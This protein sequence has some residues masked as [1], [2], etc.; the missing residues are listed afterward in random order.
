MDNPNS[1]HRGRLLER[2]EK[3]G[4]SALSD[5]EIIELLLTYVLPRR[6]LKPIAKKLLAAFSTVN[7]VLSAQAADLMKVAGI[8]S[9]AAHFFV[10]FKEVM[11]HCLRE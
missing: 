5:H 9:R 6:D 3:N 10:L 4:L 7:G 11:S 2:F 8:G 1:G